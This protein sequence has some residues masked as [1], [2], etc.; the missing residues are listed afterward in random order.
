VKAIPELDQELTRLIVDIDQKQALFA[1]MIRNAREL[2]RTLEGP[3][4]G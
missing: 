2:R 4:Q 3:Q 1:R